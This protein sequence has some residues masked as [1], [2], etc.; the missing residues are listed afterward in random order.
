MQGELEQRDNG[1]QLRF[2]RRLP[3]PPQKVWQAITEPEHLKAWFPTGVVGEWKVNTP[4]KFPS[5]YGDFDGE[6]LAVQPPSLL[7]FR[8][9]T[10]FIR[11]QVAPDPEGSVLTLIDRIDQLGKASRDAAGWH[12]CLDALER[13]LAGKESS[14][15]SE[16]WQSLDARYSQRFGPDASTIGPPEKVAR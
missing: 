1:W 10:D 4:L 14:P 2:T 8:W 11:L 5:E 15:E 13:H 16:D 12:T 7:E 3:H 9:G 6:V